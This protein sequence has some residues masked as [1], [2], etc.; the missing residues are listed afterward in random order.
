MMHAMTV[1]TN[2]INSIDANRL[3]KPLVPMT[4]A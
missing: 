2:A 4:Y 1:V 3:N